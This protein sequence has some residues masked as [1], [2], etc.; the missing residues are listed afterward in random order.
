MSQ[1]EKIEDSPPENETKWWESVLYF[2]GFII[3]IIIWIQYG[4]IRMVGTL[5]LVYWCFRWFTY[6]WLLI[7]REKVLFMWWSTEERHIGIPMYKILTFPGIIINGIMIILFL[8][9]DPFY[10]IGILAFIGLGIILLE[11]LYD[12]V[13]SRVGKSPKDKSIP[14]IATDNN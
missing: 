6:G 11:G 5:L 10:K 1:M 3:F 2:I 8:F 4:F 12:W 14:D 13:E 9:E 7:R